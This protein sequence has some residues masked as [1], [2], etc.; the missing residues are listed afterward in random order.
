MRGTS[1]LQLP[2]RE[3]VTLVTFHGVRGSNEIVL[4][5]INIDWEER[6]DR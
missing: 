3:S 4:R 2:V 5:P 1:R 6:S